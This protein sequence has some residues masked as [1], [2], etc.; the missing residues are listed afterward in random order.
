MVLAEPGAR[1][2]KMNSKQM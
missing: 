2:L 1:K